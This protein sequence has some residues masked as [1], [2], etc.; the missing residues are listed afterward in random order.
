MKRI[1]LAL[2]FFSVITP[3][4]NAQNTLKDN[5]SKHVHYLSSDAMKGRKSLSK[6]S[7]EA[8]EY[9]KKE[10]KNMGLKIYD[11]PIVSDSL[12]KFAQKEEENDLVEV[13]EEVTK[14][15]RQNKKSIIYDNFYTVI[16][17]LNN[18]YKDKNTVIYAKIY[19]NGTKNIKNHEIILNSANY[20]AS[21]CA[22]A[23][24]L[25]RYFKENQGKLKKNIIVFFDNTE[26]GSLTEEYFAKNF[27]QYPVEMFFNM[28]NL[29]FLAGEEDEKQYSYSVSFGIKN[30]SKILQPIL[31]KDVNLPTNPDYYGYYEIPV[32]IISGDWMDEFTDVAD[33]L[34]YDMMEKIV[35]QSKDVITAFNTSNVEIDFDA[36]NSST[37]SFSD[38]FSQENRSYFGLNLM[39]GSNKHYYSKGYTTGKAAMS[40]SA[41][42]FFKWQFAKSFALKLDANYERAYANRADGR[43][44]S[45]VISVPLSLMNTVGISDFEILYGIGAYYDYNLSAKLNGKDVNQDD[46][47]KGEW[48]WQFSIGMRF[49]HFMMGY[50]QKTGISDIMT[51]S[52]I[53]KGKIKNRNQ[54]FTIGWAF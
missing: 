23:M 42:V 40:Y 35:N 9:I 7:T 24:E 12:N 54:Y 10:L 48:G 11:F 45:N 32:V 20:N 25:A 14:E 51:D 26:T 8:A 22:A 4:T 36:E 38:L 1:L 19:G 21:G 52:F 18:E 43:F 41:G 15:N 28:N 50:Y 6:E 2:A 34:D 29:G 13:N 47:H 17:A 39:I 46:F 3:L 44:E 30:A 27:K 31:L 5:L 33:S 16:P 49:G 53:H 37:D